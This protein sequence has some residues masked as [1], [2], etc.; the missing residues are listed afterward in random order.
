[1]SERDTEIDFDFFEE[2]DQEPEEP[3]RRSPLR[4]APRDGPPRRPA[5]GGIAPLVRLVVVIAIAI[6]LVLLLVFLVD[7]CR[8]DGK[9]EAYEDYMADVSAVAT[10]SQQVGR[11][12]TALL[13]EAAVKQAEV[14]SRLRGLATR[15]RQGIEQASGI[16]PPGALREQHEQLIEALQLRASGLDGMANAF[17]RT[18]DVQPREAGELLADQ[19]RRLLASDIIWDDLFKEPA[20]RELERRDVTGVVVP[21]SNFLEDPNVVALAQMRSI[22]RRI[23]GATVGIPKDAIRGNGIV[24]VTALP[25]NIQLSTDEPRVIRASTRLAFRVAVENSGS[26]AEGD[27]RVTLTIRKTPAPIVKSAVIE[28]IN[29]GQ[30][31]TVT[32]TNIGAV[33]IGPRTT[34]TAEVK[35]VPNERTLENNVFEYPVFFSVA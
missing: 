3:P 35:P 11:G 13:N 32:F 6:A 9:A 8:G 23:R 1:M 15:Q 26:V 33:D 27:V 12:F 17:P 10:D 21:D 14:E 19:V 22:Y 24:S 28:L 16:D 31:Q 18:T 34:V 7:R 25:Q 29:P 5:G 20:A 30:T 4:R 2:P